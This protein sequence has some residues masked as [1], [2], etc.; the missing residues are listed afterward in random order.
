MAQVDVPTLLS[1]LGESVARNAG[2]PDA[3]IAAR[4]SYT[5]RFGKWLSSLKGSPAGLPALSMKR[6][7]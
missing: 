5:L 4:R 3:E 1:R 7:S 6:R 2:I